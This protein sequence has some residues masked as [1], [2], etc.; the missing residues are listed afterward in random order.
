MQDTVIDHAIKKGFGIVRMDN[1][2]TC[3]MMKK[4]THY[5]TRYLE[6]SVDGY[7]NGEEDYKNVILHLLS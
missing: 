1:D 5:S 7:A 6:V 4:V 3:Y 2:G